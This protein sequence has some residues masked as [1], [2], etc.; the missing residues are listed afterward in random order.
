M[1]KIY[2]NL[3]KVVC[4]VT[5]SCLTLCDPMDCSPPGSSVH[6]ILQVRILEWIAIPCS[7]RSSLPRGKT[8][9]SCLAGIFFTIEPPGKPYEKL[10]R[11]KLGLKKKHSFLHLPGPSPKVA[12]SPKTVD[13][14]VPSEDLG[15]LSSQ[16]EHCSGCIFLLLHQLSFSD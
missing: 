16:G 15:V 1:E 11:A 6:G 5:Q 8:R 4:L 9:V 3:P 12:A 2:G 14:S 10:H 7:R 13:T